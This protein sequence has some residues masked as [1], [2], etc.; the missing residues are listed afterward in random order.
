M[1][2]F[3]N[4]FVK[5]G[6]I[7]VLFLCALMIF[8]P[9]IYNIPSLRHP[10]FSDLDRREFGLKVHVSAVEAFYRNREVSVFALFYLHIRDIRAR[11]CYSQW[12]MNT[13]KLE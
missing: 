6:L 7:V 11:F 2:V 12:P 9:N 10:A 3:K 13:S 5:V 4:P 1:I 8:S